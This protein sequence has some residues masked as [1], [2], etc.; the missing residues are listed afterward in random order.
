M[1]N[2]FKYILPVITFLI[3]TACGVESFEPEIKLNPPLDLSATNNSPG[4]ILVNF[5]GFN[6]ED[7]FSGYDIYI[8]TS[9]DDLN[10]NRGYLVYRPDGSSSTN[11]PTLDATPVNSETPFTYVINK[12][13]FPTNYNLTTGSIQ[14]SSTY[15]IYVKAYS[16]LYNLYSNP[17]FYTNGVTI[18]Q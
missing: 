15:F 14:I 18:F 7:Y 8:A 11:Q 4:Q 13:T 2:I 10:N 12:R 3:F 9:V 1:N 6:S 16:V 17:C 5:E